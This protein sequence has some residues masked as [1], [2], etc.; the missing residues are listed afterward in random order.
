MYND[1]D[2][3]VASSLI[4]FAIVVM[5]VMA[6]TGCATSVPVTAKFPERPGTLVST[7]CPA[8]KKLPDEVALSEVAKT[9]TENY[10][11]YYECAVK[12]DAWIKWYEIQK[13]I[14]EGAGK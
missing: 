12:L 10:T 4:I 6:L 11:Q 1:R 2:Q 3:G 7:P 14:Y 5:L 8:L 9:I 13:T